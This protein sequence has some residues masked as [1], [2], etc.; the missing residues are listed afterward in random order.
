MKIKKYVWIAFIL[1][2]GFL[3]GSALPQEL[4]FK[5][6]EA[7]TDDGTVKAGIVQALN[8]PQT[9]LFVAGVAPEQSASVVEGCLQ[10][11]HFVLCY[12]GGELVAGAGY[13]VDRGYDSAALENGVIDVPDCAYVAQVF[14]AQ[15]QRR[16]GV[17]TFLI[18]Q[19]I[20]AVQQRHP[21][22]TAL[23]GDVLVENSG[24]AHFYEVLGARKMG[25]WFSKKLNKVLIVYSY[26]L[27]DAQ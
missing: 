27:C 2:A 20:A 14:V 18:R 12:K 4:V 7:G 10:K 8:D 3:R 6:L 11:Y 21:H 17:G 19:L 9:S 25:E 26:G 24:A 16:Q 1:M 13:R 5:I 22:V 15:E 23:H